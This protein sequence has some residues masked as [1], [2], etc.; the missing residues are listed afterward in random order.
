M[1]PYCRP[2]HRLDD[3]LPGS[4]NVNESINNVYT[5]KANK[6]FD[7]RTSYQARVDVAILEKTQGELQFYKNLCSKSKLKVTKISA[8]AEAIKKEEDHAAKIALKRK[9]T[10]AKTHRVLNKTSKTKA[11]K[12]AAANA[13]D[14]YGVQPTSRKIANKKLKSKQLVEIVNVDKP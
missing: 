6:R 7:F 9:T 2:S 13:T 1:R 3:L 10:E 8:A 5:I 11:L 12:R 4:S 14:S